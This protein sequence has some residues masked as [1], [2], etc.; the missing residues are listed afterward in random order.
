[1][2]EQYKVVRLLG[3]GGMG[4][5]VLARDVE[6]G[7]RVALKVIDPGLLGSDKDVA[8]FLFEAR[9]T[10][11][12][13]HPHIVTIYGVGRHQGIPFM[14]L[15]YL[16]GQTLRRRM[17]EA[18]LGEREAVRFALAV[19]EALEES[20]AHGV[21][22]GDLKP[23]NVLIA[24]DGRV[25][26][27]DFGLARVVGKSRR[28]DEG[29]ASVDTDDPGE[30]SGSDFAS[31]QYMAPELWLDQ[32]SSELSDIWSLGVILFEMTAGRRPY[33]ETDLTRLGTRITAP[34]LAPRV[35]RFRTVRSELTDLVARCLEKKPQMRPSAAEVAVRLRDLLAR[36]GA[37]RSREEPPYRGLRPF[38][39]RHCHV[40]FGRD[41]EID[42][43]LERVREQGVLPVVGASGVGK[44]SFVQ[45]GVIPR[46][47][48]QG[49]WTV[50]SLRP[51]R[52]PFVDLEAVL[53]EHEEQEY[54][55]DWD[56]PSTYSLHLTTAQMEEMSEPPAPELGGPLAHRLRE[57]PNQLNLV[58]QEI[59]ENTGTRVL[60][61]VD[62]LEEL[63]TLVEDEEIQ[64]RF[65]LAITAAGDDPQ[66]P[67][68]V[69]FTVRDDFLGRVHLGDATRQALSQVTVLQ[70]PD[71][72]AMEQMLLQPLRSV[73]YS[74]DD[75]TLV[76]HMVE[77]VRDEP[78]CLPLL[79]FT[80]RM[81]WDRRD[82]ESRQLRRATYDAMGGVAG[83]LA[84]HADGLL[85]GL[86]PRDVK[87]ARK[88]LLRLVTP[89]GTRRVLPASQV[90]EGGGKRATRVLGQL[91][92]A[93]LV[94]VRKSSRGHEGE[95]ELE[96]VHESLIRSWSQLAR[97]ID[98]SREELAVLSQLIQVAELWQQRGR[99]DEELWDGDALHEAHR[100]LRRSSMGIPE[101]VEEFLRAG[102]RKDGRIRR[103][104]RILVEV[105]VGLLALIALSSAV[106]A[107]VMAE[108]KAEMKRQKDRAEVQWDLAESRR[109]E[110]QR[111][112]ARGALERGAMLEA[113]AKLRASL[114]TEDSLLGRALW[115]R[116][117]RDPLI[118]SRELGTF[119]YKVAW[120]P[121]GETLAAACQDRSIYLFGGLTEAV[122]VL[123]GH[124]EQ[125][126]AV[127]FSP[128]GK[129][130]AS[131]SW[132]A[133]VRIWDLDTGASQVVP[134]H[135]GRVNDVRFSPDGS[136]L[137][138]TA[139]DNLTRLL[140]LDGR[141]VFEGRGA[142]NSTVAFSPDG[143]LL[144]AGTHEGE[145]QL[146]DVAAR[147]S[148]RS[149]PGHAA[150]VAG[151][152]F[153][154]RG[155]HL[156]TYSQDHD[157]RVWTVQDGREVIALLGHTQPI[158]SVSFLADGQHLI[159]ASNDGT[160]RLW[161]MTDGTH[162]PLL[163]GDAVS[164]RAAGLAPDGK[165]LAVASFDKALRV[166]N[167][168]VAEDLE[169]VVGGHADAI[170]G[171]SFGL[172]DTTVYSASLDGTIRAWDVTT[173]ETVGA[174]E[175]HTHGVCSV[176]TT[177]EGDRLVSGSIDGTLRIWDT[178]T[179]AELAVLSG[180]S[181]R[182]WGVAVSPDGRTAASAGS[183]KSVRVWDLV[184]G[185]EIHHLH[186]H[187][188]G[189][190]TVSFSPD[191]TRLA[192]S[193]L[194]ETVLIWRLATGAVERRLE[195]HT[196]E[197]MGL[198]FSPDGR[199]V[200]TGSFD[201]SV[202]L[203]DLVS[204]RSRILG[205]HEARVHGIAFDPTG[206]RLGTSCADGTARVW[207]VR[208][209]EYVKLAG[210]L[211][212]ANTLTFGRGGSIVATGGDDRTVRLWRADTGEPIWR[213]TALLPAPPR[214][215]GHNGWVSLDPDVHSVPAETAW[216]VA[217]EARAV[218]ATASADARTGCLLDRDS[219]L[220]IWDTSAGAPSQVA[221]LAKVD[222][223][224][225][226]RDACVVLASDHATLHHRDGTA[227]ELAEDARAL[228][229][230]AGGLMV[231]TSGQVLTFS[232]AGEPVA[233]VAVGPAVSAVARHGDWLLLGYDN[234]NIERVSMTHGSAHA[235]LHFED[236]VS[237]AVLRL[238]SGPM[239]T[240]V[241]GHANGRVGL[242]SLDNGLLLEEASLHGPVTRLD[243]LGDS[244]VA[245][246]GLGDHLRWDLTT[247]TADRCDLL[248]EVW[249]AVPVVWENGL[250]VP[251]TPPAG[252][253]CA[254]TSEDGR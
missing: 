234:G 238:A 112:G 102:L 228:T 108:N 144:A 136:L 36:H 105:G 133:S 195:G 65:M 44:S 110:A 190:T 139:N 170:Y 213:G 87:Q 95:S 14:A 186:G 26:V 125:V 142:R 55:D 158:T 154:P 197:V 7:R 90:L 53:A 96:L 148:R 210:H 200:A 27:L 62:Q 247:L 230:D 28:A 74:V 42:A 196:G 13:N 30:G 39:E 162:R 251:A 203:W 198:A 101:T 19:A 75:P 225:A 159:S 76:P 248:Q 145:I 56:E 98:E 171:L 130:L 67:V 38:S 97:W 46:L 143:T 94:V 204:G 199:T 164:A 157:I 231:A 178:D 239:G 207:D 1:M 107:G 85:D 235:G 233:S 6:L 169:E 25:R 35:N 111:E 193:G 175:G 32:E 166:W 135:G 22:H 34:E 78:A 21:Q 174:F 119:I 118:W 244:L 168:P 61:F 141:V 69:V 181:A 5:V 208:S 93:R 113:K 73:G 11:R 211:D 192:S 226:T 41:P 126:A 43:F 15:E 160:L 31:P 104:T 237:S 152:A 146:I 188:G 216:S 63:Y 242:W 219:S 134:G 155:R 137:A 115:W 70:R 214:L 153:G 129:T 236:T 52:R 29:G 240:A 109:A 224:V 167:L 23:T 84:R 100:A 189:A 58:L 40:F 151:V 123:R 180:H 165:R 37:M 185:H 49:R 33:T 127:A 202:R 253:E 80:A 201:R 99:R 8:R 18:Q 45:A 20:H 173:G 17:G 88:I 50:V 217:V 194:D 122:R 191:G 161:S 184:T 12:F 252:H 147:D 91:V 47:R 103:R 179:G 89:E 120:S 82:Q 254:R 249:D 172:D 131:G 64:R 10:A 209:G 16:E 121:D 150:S 206:R 9:A 92:D 227:T 79:Q 245:A 116:V 60:L 114:E 241:A 4:E 218:Q 149:W 86:P 156:A 124:Q 205:E 250:P 68:R 2:V 71:P 176:A 243:V 229:V 72:P 212:E 83:A 222:Q 3:R 187:P 215:L 128:D 183:D 220:E 232:T 81:L 77:S 59:A 182:V 223:I 54:V 177:P 57:A 117:G 51:G 140:D 48:E 66:S 221:R 246:T 163:A 106:V 132:D 138:T 24:R